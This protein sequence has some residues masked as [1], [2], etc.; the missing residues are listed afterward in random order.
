M[1]EVKVGQVWEDCDPRH[2]DPPRQ[3][4]IVSQAN[5]DTWRVENVSTGRQTLVHAK[6]FR[7][8]QTGYRLVA[9][10]PAAAHLT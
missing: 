6:R 7:P 4:R 9:Q 5:S 1:E 8:R 3:I 10:A 2:Q